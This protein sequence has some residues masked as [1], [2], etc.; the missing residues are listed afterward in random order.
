MA[1]STPF[2]AFKQLDLASALLGYSAPIRK[3][4]ATPRLSDILD[5]SGEL[6]AGALTF[7]SEKALAADGVRELFDSGYLPTP[8]AMTTLLTMPHETLGRGYG[9]FLRATGRIPPRV[10][11]DANL[12]DPATY[13][14]LRLRALHGVIHV[15]TGYDASTTG[16]LAVQSFYLGQFASP[17]SATI[18]T[19]GMM[20]LLRDAPTNLGSLF[21]VMAEGY[22]RGRESRPILAVPWEELWMAPISD[23][24]EL[25]GLAPRT[26]RIATL[27]LRSATGTTMPHA[28]R[29][30]K[31]NPTLPAPPPP[32]TSDIPRARR[33]SSS[34]LVAAFA[35]LNREAS[36]THP[37]AAPVK[38]GTPTQQPKKPVTSRSPFGIPDDDDDGPGLP[39]PPRA[40][41]PDED[42]P[43]YF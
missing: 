18:I 21:E 43:D 31:L 11:G 41:Y 38:N 10:P 13:I 9:E 35:Q 40:P 19:A 25:A 16:E 17:A 23:V 5:T 20:Q 24:V 33:Q 12:S 15:V 32:E 14:Q 28:E 34:S 30:P 22:S 7:D 6:D 26:C 42:D 36:Q 8:E 2:E 27:T 4:A 29:R 3:Q 39:P 37:E 1:T